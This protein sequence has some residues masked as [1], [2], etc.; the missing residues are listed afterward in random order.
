MTDNSL[1]DAFHRICISEAPLSERLSSFSEVVRQFGRPFAEVY[2]DLVER[3]RSGEAGK[4]APMPGDVMPPFLLPDGN[5]QLV[6]LDALLKDGPAVISFNRGHWCEYC[7][8][9]LAAFRAALSEFSRTGARVVSIMPEAQSFI[10][11]TQH[12]EAFPILADIDNGYALSL[13]LAIWLGEDVRRLY[14]EL[15]LHLETYQGNDTWLL[16]IPAT[17]VV[18][19]NGRI[20]DRFVDP[21]FRNRMDIADILSALN[22]SSV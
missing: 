7:L 15:G 13:G 20:I 12:H 19:R 1:E 17:F 11:L 10:S 14:L 21:D 18:G 8:I 5:N 3:I 6:S 2:D 22:R 4:A 16:P 9:E